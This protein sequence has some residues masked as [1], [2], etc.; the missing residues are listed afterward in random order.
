MGLGQYIIRRILL[1]IPILLVVSFLAFSVIHLAP[2]DPAQMMVNPRMGEEVIQQVREKL[3]LNRPLHIQYFIFLRRMVTGDFGASLYT[4]QKVTE[5]IIQRLPST[6][7]LMFTGLTLA[8]LLAIPIGIMAAVH[9]GGPG[10]YLSMTIALIGIGVP[11]FW[12]G[13]L[14]ILVFSVRLGW[15]PVSGTGDIR[16]LV[17]PAVTLAVTSMAYVARVMRSSMLEFLKKDFV[18]T[19][20]AKGQMERFVVLKHVLRNAL[21]PIIALFGLDFGWMIGGAVMVEYVFNRA[22]LGRLMVDSIYMRDY[23]V[24]QVLL[25]FLTTSVI[26]GNLT[27]DILLAFMDPRISHK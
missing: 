3:G 4:R 20:R 13:L 22:G 5:M 17:L 18:I 21:G 1:A 8:Y 23:P 15:F 25:L 24:F 14:L 6:L 12:L 16:H 10:D 27:G 11:R 26:L 19:A 9:K 2:G 7:I